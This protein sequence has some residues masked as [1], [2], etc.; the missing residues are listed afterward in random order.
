MSPA[1]WF[2]AL[3]F[4]LVLLAYLPALRGGFIWDD[5]GHV[6]RSDLRSLAGLAR[7]WF[8]P[9]ATQQYYPLLHSA[10]WFEHLLWGDAPFGYH[11]L[12]V[13]LH[14]ANACLFA[15]LL[16]RLAVPGAWFAAL[17]FAL[18][19]VCVESVAW[20]A[21]QK[22]SLSALLYLCAALAYLRF[23]SARTGR[24]YAVATLLFLAALLTKTVTATLP[25][26]LLVIFWWQRGSLAWRRDV[27]PLLP[28]FALGA[29]SGL[30]TA[31]FERELIGASGA[32]FNFSLADRLVIAGRVV[33]FYLG[34]LAW[35]A[36]LIF[37]YPRWTID[38]GSFAQWLGL[39]AALLLLAGVFWY[40]RRSRAPLA[41]T[42]LFAGT[43]FPVLGF[44]NVYPFVFSF[45]AD[46]FQYL[47]S[48]AIFALAGAGA[49]RLSTRFPRPRPQ[50][51]AFGAAPLLLLG[52]LTWAQAGMY[53]DVFTL[54][55]TTLAR[56]PDA[57]M[58][59]N[60]LA[61]ELTNRGRVAE[62]I[63]HLE[64][65]LQLRPHDAIAESNLG[66]DL[67]RQGRPTE[68]LPHLE[69]AVKLQPNFAN[70]HNNLGAALSALGRPDEALAHHQEALRLQPDLASAEHN[71]GLVL[72]M[73]GKNAEAI[74][75]FQRA[76][77]LD[78]QFPA[79]ELSW[80]IALMLSGRFDDAVPHFERACDLDPNSVDSH[81]TFGRA[82]AQHRRLAEAV[83]QFQ[84]V[85][86][87]EPRLGDAH[88][89]L[90]LV[91]RA[92]GRSDEAQNHFLQARQ[93]GA[94]S[95]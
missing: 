15:A 83:E 64:K 25:A 46:H 75:H 67:L 12:N 40:R 36:D 45:V 14:A 55:E 77:A 19:P 80:G 47:A 86:E 5:S 54:Y 27:V 23:N 49:A 6:T 71:I 11:L 7:I 94:S 93:L 51:L 87:L 20:V 82:L 34:K 66:D 4:L 44:F 41:A 8:E 92:L 59:H 3:T 95:P 31:H 53:R 1:V 38:A 28:W 9:G 21:E 57:W 85:L 70:A 52:A 74:P 69:R 73:S 79:A 50:F 81:F 39:F 18:H 88:Q 84:I 89:Q 48:L 43:L 65:V 13:L 30:F 62:A 76:A 61:M 78:P 91:L 33:W 42:L 2:G 29:A 17:L 72:A 16:R 68:A 22:N 24:A 56:N 37:I 26:A 10:F 35:P 60:N 32:D 90:A 63:P 58:A